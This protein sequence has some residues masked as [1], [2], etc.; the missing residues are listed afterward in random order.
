MSKSS[1]GDRIVTVV[2]P[3]GTYS[4]VKVTTTVPD[5]PGAKSPKLGVRSFQVNIPAGA[6]ESGDGLAPTNCKWVGL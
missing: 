2:T 1:R 6:V 5:A 4:A 3:P